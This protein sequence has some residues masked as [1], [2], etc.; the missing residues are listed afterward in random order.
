[1]TPIFHKACLCDSAAE[2]I[3]RA[4][5]PRFPHRIAHGARFAPYLRPHRGQPASPAIPIDRRHAGQT[6]RK[7][8]A[9]LSRLENETHR[10]APCARRSGR[11]TLAF[12]AAL[13]ASSAFV[14]A[15]RGECVRDTETNVTFSNFAVCAGLGAAGWLILHGTDWD[16]ATK[17]ERDQA[18]AEC[19]T[20]TNWV[21]RAYGLTEDDIET[22][23]RRRT[24]DNPEPRSLLGRMFPRAMKIT[25]SLPPTFF[26]APTARGG[27]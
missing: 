7:R 9:P 25:S 27:C 11:L 6:S 17:A 23:T 15:S 26:T 18:W 5:R 4:S 1:M 16:K 20:A 21:Q 3:S 2:K 22:L 12:L 13:T 24:A 8:R 10:G 19:G 14:T